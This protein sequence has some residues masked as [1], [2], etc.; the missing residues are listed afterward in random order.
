MKA[1][2]KITATLVVTF[3]FAANFASANVGTIVDI[4]LGEQTATALDHSNREIVRFED[5]DPTLSMGNG[6]TVDF[7]NPTEREARQG[8][9]PTINEVLE[10]PA[11]R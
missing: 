5:V 3:L 10:C 8:A 11:R 9:E 2:T 4:N 7:Y 1:I 6:C